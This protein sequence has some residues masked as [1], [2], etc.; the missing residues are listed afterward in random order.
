MRSENKT[1]CQVLALPFKLPELLGSLGWW[2]R[3]LLGL[4]SLDAIV[5]LNILELARAR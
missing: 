3:K 5:A 4:Q 1:V 2:P